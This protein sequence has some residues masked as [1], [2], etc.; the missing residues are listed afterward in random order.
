[1][2]ILVHVNEFEILFITNFSVKDEILKPEYKAEKQKLCFSE[3][4][5]VIMLIILNK[6]LIFK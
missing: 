6:D 1:M 3:D 4:W 5:L 2:L